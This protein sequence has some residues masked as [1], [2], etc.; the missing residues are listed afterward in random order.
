MIAGVPAPLIAL[1]GLLGGGEA[2]TLALVAAGL[3]LL[4]V[5]LVGM[6]LLDRRERRQ[7]V[8]A[9]V[10]T[11]EDL[12]SG[13]PPH[14]IPVGERSPLG[15][16]SDAVQR[17]GQDLTL[18]RREVEETGQRL[19]AVMH[20]VHDI[21][22]VST[23]REG[24]IQTFSPGAAELF[25]WSESD[26]AA[27]PVEILF[28]EAWKEFLPRL[29]PRSLPDEG[30]DVRTPMV[31]REGE[32][33]DALVEVR[34]LRGRGGEPAGFMIV[35]RDVSAQARRERELR[36]SEARYR[37][38]LEGL[39]VGV[40]VLRHSRV[41]YAN[42]ALAALCGS[43]PDELRDAPW[44]DYL[45]ARDVLL[46]QDRL[47]ALEDDGGEPLEL[48]LTLDPPGAAARPRV[49]LRAQAIEDDDG[50]AVLCTVED[51]TVERR[52]WSELR[53]NESR[54]D[55][56]LEASPD[57]VLV[58]ARTPEGG[59][60]HLTNRAF[61]TRFGLGEREVLGA[62][63]GHLLR[64]LRQRGEGAEDVATLLA[65]ANGE[66]RSE[67]VRLGGA[68]PTDL[69]VTVE[70]LRDRRGTV[71]GRVAVFRDLTRQRASERELETRGEELRRRK[72]ALEQA[73]QE[74]SGLN[75]ELELRGKKQQQLNEELRALD[76]MKSDLLGNVTHELQTPLVSVR[77]YTE[78]ILKGRLGAVSEEQ[79]KGLELSLKNIDRMIS[80]IDSLLAIPKVEQ[81]AG[82]MRP[83][84]FPLRPLIEECVATLRER[85]EARN[86]DLSLSF[87]APD[88]TAHGDREMLLQVFLNLLGNAV[89]FNRQGGSIEL[90]V[91]RGRSG[92]LR[93]EVRD[94]GVGIP[95]Q[96]LER[97][98]DRAYRSGAAAE[99]EP[100]SGLGLAI[101]R[102]LLRLHGCTI[103]AESE[104]GRGSVFSFTVPSADRERGTVEE[105]SAPPEPE[106]PTPKPDPP[107]PRER[108]PQDRRGRL[109]IIRR[110]R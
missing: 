47:T 67:T 54:L 50:R 19:D 75:Q 10:Q 27:R 16:V 6:L 9:I 11:V 86:L 61:L 12:R 95:R 81:E 96:D 48:E 110:Q 44:R 25:G 79:K 28:G 88:P 40:L 1:G 53:H 57:G 29:A 30:I 105:A 20:A 71:L 52:L 64:L 46:V 17:L 37:G 3:L 14:R 51:R 4:V 97:I 43:A 56:V 33:F 94:S 45:D 98:F 39:E 59:V 77:G 70:D 55:S 38:L 109:R 76:R 63:E 101:V 42:P 91:R 2:T 68:Q 78:M 108:V 58:L 84:V 69:E 103:R 13:H 41:L 7:E 26:L 73:Y 62:S 80:M 65:A 8:R 93:V 22:V 87:E 66:R 32:V 85:I 36:A 83:V 23:D 89:K 92:L 49:R 31:K 5:A 104:E 74:L 35:V 15:L 100:G 72:A 60:V 107:A 24:D 99:R 90:R 21:A 106:P 82:R 18:R 102:D 34:S